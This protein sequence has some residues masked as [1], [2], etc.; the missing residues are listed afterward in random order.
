MDSVSQIIIPIPEDKVFYLQEHGQFKPEHLPYIASLKI[1]FVETE[2]EGEPKYLGITPDMKASYYIGADWLTPEKAV[3]ITP[4]MPDIDYVRMY[5][6]VLRFAPSASYFSKFYGINFSGNKIESENL[7]SIL[8]PLLLIHFLS[9][10]DKLLEKGL[11]RGYVT[12]EEN[13]EAKIKG[14]VMMSKQYNKNITNHRTD[15]IMC[16]YQEYSADIPENRLI[17]KALLFAK[18]TI[19]VMPAILCHKVYPKISHMLQSSLVAFEDVSDHID[20][21]SV[22]TVQ[23]NK[24]FG[25]YGTAIK[26]A[27]Q[28]LKRYDYSISNIEGKKKLVPPFWIDMARLYEVYVYGL[29]QKAYP[30]QIKFQVNGHYHTAVDFLKMDEKLIMDTK[31]KPQYDSSN[32]GIIDDIREI[33]G[34]ARDEY[35]LNELG[36]PEQDIVPNCLIIYPK[37]EDCCIVTAFSEGEPL[38]PE[39]TPIN[40]FRRFYKICVP[41]P[42]KKDDF[43]DDLKVSGSH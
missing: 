8:T 32:S 6:S 1:N 41:V 10:V 33:S 34:Y 13:L 30:G 5:M 2:Y 23:Q 38:L 4:K 27:K 24:L 22:K 18:R 21:S 26:L 42:I 3:V 25:D 16:S 7:D 14:K 29:L 40:G 35:I 12:R 39:S 20:I 15:R 9:S 17:K 28:L 36:I 43:I 31:Y 19:S 37:M 11:K